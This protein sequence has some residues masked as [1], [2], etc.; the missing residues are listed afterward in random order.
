[1]S[2]DLAPHRILVGDEWIASAEPELRD[3]LNP[4]TG[5]VIGRVS[6]GSA[7]DVDRA[8]EAAARAF[9]DWSRTT[10]QAR[11][12]ALLEIAGTLA[13]RKEE[14]A[15]TESQNV[16]KPLPMAR[17]EIDYACDNLR[18]FAGAAR[19]L[20]TQ[21]A[22]EYL[23]GYTS[24]LRREPVGIVGQITPWNYPLL[25][26][27]WKLGP[28]LATGN[29]VVLKPAEQTPLTTLVLG[30]VC[31]EILPPGVVNVVTGE[32]DP[33]GARLASHPAV[34]M[35][36]LTGGVATGKRVA[37]AAAQTLKRVHLELGGKAP[38]VVF[39]DADL[40]AVTAAVRGMGYWNAGQEC[41]AACRVLVAERVHDELL[42]ALVPAV[43]SIAVGDPAGGEHVEMG[44]LISARQRE[45][46]SGF[47]ARALASSG[48]GGARVL[49]GGEALA[50]PGYFMQP[51]LIAG[52]GHTDELSQHEVFGPVVSV[53]RCRDDDELVRCANDVPYGLAAS[54][55]TRDVGRALSAASELRFGTVWINDHLPLVSEMPWSGFRGS[56]YGADCSAHALQDYTQLKHVM[57][58]HATSA[59]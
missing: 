3:I 20:A 6:R 1:M 21:A 44:P 31:A 19:T 58:S 41:G 15:Q 40:E 59:R 26:A 45:R 33:V 4:A 47:V 43:A 11:A 54:V 5:A 55:W 34:D 30:A 48:G 52:V 12:D 24:M 22:G 8:V 36:S 37:A 29:V 57:A 9:G 25:M 42:D 51:T 39:A 18:F 16:G 23:S 38:V 14:L 49:A 35:V 46:V 17:D 50:G 7:A 13:R 53:Q 56:G 10:P 32:G 2:V 28:A 27:V